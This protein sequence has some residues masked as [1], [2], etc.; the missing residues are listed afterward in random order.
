MANRQLKKNPI[1][2]TTFFRTTKIKLRRLL[3]PQHSVKLNVDWFAKYD[4]K[5]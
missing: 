5:Q 4:G 2:K 3:I 1:N